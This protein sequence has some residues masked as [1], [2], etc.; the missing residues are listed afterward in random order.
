MSRNAKRR[1]EPQARCE[2]R[3]SSRKHERGHIDF[4]RS[5][6]FNIACERRHD[7]FCEHDHGGIGAW[8]TNLVAAC[9]ARRQCLRSDGVVLRQCGAM[10]GSAWW[11]SGQQA[12]RSDDG[13]P[14][15]QPQLCSIV[16]GVGAEC[17][18]RS[19]RGGQWFEQRDD[20]RGRAGDGDIQRGSGVR[21]EQLCGE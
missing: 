10:H 17:G 4:G 19:Q 20:T 11:K 3:R 15:G 2:H 1:Q 5:D 6:K 14:G 21:E 13:C 9:P 18:E 12:I 16:F 8:D 7:G